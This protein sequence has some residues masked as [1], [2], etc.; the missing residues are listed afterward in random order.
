VRPEAPLRSHLLL[1][2]DTSIGAGG[3]L[4]A[5]DL[6]RISL[7]RTRIAILSGCHT[8]SGRLSYTEGTSSLARAFF[9]AGVPTVIASLWAVIDEETAEFFSAF[10]RDLARGID[11]V[12]AL[13]LTQIEWISMPG[14]GWTTLSTWAAFQLFGSTRGLAQNA[15]VEPN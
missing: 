14:G 8:A 6:F 3:A 5:K 15:P 12:A 2:P 7:P 4:Y 13:R 10:H 9:A 1:A 11:P